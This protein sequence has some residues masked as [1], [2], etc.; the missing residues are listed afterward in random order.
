MRPTDVPRRTLPA[1]ALWPVRGAAADLPQRR[2]DG[3]TPAP[4]ATD[5]AVLDR[6]QVA[7][8]LAVLTPER[9]LVLELL[10]GLR[11]P[12]DWDGEPGERWPP[13]CAAVGRY[14]GVVVRGRRPL[15]ENT[16][17][18]IRDRARAQ[19]RAHF[20]IPEPAEPPDGDD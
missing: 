19:V 18:Y 6:V 12:D 20:G 1:G 14:I 11:V 16:V 15:K 7:Q 9:R 3:E 4:A 8:F 2:T 10:A 17:R 13:T 5:A